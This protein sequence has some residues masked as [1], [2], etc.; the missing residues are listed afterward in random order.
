[1]TMLTYFIHANP[2]LQSSQVSNV[3][4]KFNIYPPQLQLLTAKIFMPL[5][6]VVWPEALFSCLFVRPTVRPSVRASVL[7][8]VNALIHFGTGIN[9]SNFEVKRSKSKVMVK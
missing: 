5:P 3:N 8:I 2:I 1:M 6:H 4:N 7:N 9:A